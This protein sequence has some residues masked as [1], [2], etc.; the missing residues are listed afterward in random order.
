MTSDTTHEIQIH[1]RIVMKDG[2]EMR[3]GPNTDGDVRLDFSGTQYGNCDPMWI[4]PMPV[5]A[6]LAAAI[7]RVY[8]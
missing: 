2:R 4:I 3:V 7:Q 6:H 8:G 1:T 5:A